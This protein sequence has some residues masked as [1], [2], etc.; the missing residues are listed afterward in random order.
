M[1][2]V[3][4]FSSDYSS[5]G[6]LA[7]SPPVAPASSYESSLGGWSPKVAAVVWLRMLKVIGNINDIQDAS[8]HTEA[9]A[10]LN[11]I[12]NGLSNVSGWGQ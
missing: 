12:W 1:I 2:S 5:D 6:L 8:G 9:I 11:H 10:G 3:C 4:D 7:T